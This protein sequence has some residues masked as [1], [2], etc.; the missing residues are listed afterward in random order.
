M[1]DALDPDI[2]LLQHDFSA[3]ASTACAGDNQTADILFPK[4]DFLAHINPE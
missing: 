4:A 1:I 2:E 3:V